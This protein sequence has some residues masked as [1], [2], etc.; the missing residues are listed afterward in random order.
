VLVQDNEEMSSSIWNTMY[1][2]EKDNEDAET[3]P[4]EK[5]N[6]VPEY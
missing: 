4:Q 3:I 6:C 1:M 5:K 2:K